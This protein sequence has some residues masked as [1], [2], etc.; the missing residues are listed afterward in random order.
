MPLSL[1]LPPSLSLLLSPSL[2]LWIYV[3]LSAFKI[4]LKKHFKP[5]MGCMKEQEAGVVSRSK[6]RAVKRGP[7]DRSETAQDT[8]V[9]RGSQWCLTEPSNGPRTYHPCPVWE[10]SWLV[11]AVSHCSS[12]NFLI[13]VWGS[14]CQSASLAFTNMK[15]SLYSE[16]FPCCFSPLILFTSIATNASFLLLILSSPPVSWTAQRTQPQKLL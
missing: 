8:L 3:Y 5:T 14:S 12:W 7:P 10:P 4:F 1:S 2:Y 6:E 13:S 15:P 9:H 16:V 11:Y